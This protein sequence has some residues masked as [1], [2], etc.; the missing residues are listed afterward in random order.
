MQLKLCKSACHLPSFTEHKL[1]FFKITSSVF[2]FV[3][4]VWS[5]VGWVMALMPREAITTK[6]RGKK[7]PEA[8]Q[9]TNKSHNKIGVNKNIFTAADWI[10]IQ[11]S[12]C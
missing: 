2:V 3:Y 9:V 7:N 10:T 12:T 1:S 4:T 8:E 5:V 6:W 11:F